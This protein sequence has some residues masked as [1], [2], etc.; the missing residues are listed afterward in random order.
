MRFAV[1]PF[2]VIDFPFF[3]ETLAEAVFTIPLHTFIRKYNLGKDQNGSKQHNRNNCF[4]NFTSI[5][6]KTREFL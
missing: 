6:D 4:H 1:K 3:G 2:A 5:S